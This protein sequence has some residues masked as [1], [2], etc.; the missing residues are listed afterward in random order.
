MSSAEGTINTG[1]WGS[2]QN[3]LWVKASRPALERGAGK[4]VVTG[5]LRWEGWGWLRRGVWVGAK[6][7]ESFFKGD[8]ESLMGLMEKGHDKTVELAVP[9]QS[10]Q[11][12]STACFSRRVPCR[13]KGWGTSNRG[14]TSYRHPEGHCLSYHSNM[15]SGVG[16][17]SW[18]PKI[19]RFHKGRI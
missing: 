11:G 5:D 16:T 6:C 12:W 18:G 10:G 1:A 19:F 7:W 15:S 17:G 14:L 9:G 13:V 8:G 2:N 3:H 4:G